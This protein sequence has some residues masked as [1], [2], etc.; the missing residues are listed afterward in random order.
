[1]GDAAVVTYVRLN[2]RVGGDGAVHRRLR[3]NA[4]VA[5]PERPLETRPFSPLAL[6]LLRGFKEQSHAAND[7]RS[8]S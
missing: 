5:A 4:R 6:T 2:Q 7:S 3:G 8:A 1:M